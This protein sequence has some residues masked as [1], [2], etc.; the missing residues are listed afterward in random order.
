LAA[1]RV[2]LALGAHSDRPYAEILAAARLAED[3]GYEAVFVSETWG[4]DAFT[5]L[6]ALGRDTSRVRLGTGI[7][8]VFSRSAA[9]LA[10]AAASVNEISA[11]RM[12][13]GIGT[14]GERVI[15]RWHGIPNERPLERLSATV[16]TVRALIAGSK[17]DTFALKLGP[18]SIPIWVASLTPAGIALA[19]R[20]A[21]GWMGY[22]YGPES[23]SPDRARVES[24]V[25]AS[26]R[27]RSAFTIAPY[28]YA[29]V[30]DDAGEA[31]A[32]LRRHIAFYVGSMG[33]F[34]R[35][36]LAR[37]GYREAAEGIASLTAAG[38]RDEARALVTDELVDAYALAGDES[39]VRARL[40]DYRTSGV[41]LPIVAL[42]DGLGRDQLARTIRA[43]AS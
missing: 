28:V 4:R 24:A 43:F 14:S 33:R 8:N 30:A 35:E 22:F 3:A 1:T 42:P 36:H 15:E 39:H 12:I 41:D 40:D 19:G 32:I 21:D 9:L 2:A 34:Y 6:A 13:L 31:R 16:D 37:H 5:T 18:S 17:R 10:M 27:P 20:L 38:R 29:T 7:V 11:G 26:G 25:A 23:A